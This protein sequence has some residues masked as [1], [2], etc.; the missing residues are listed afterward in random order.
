MTYNYKRY[1]K[2]TKAGE[3]FQTHETH[4]LRYKFH[5]VVL[6]FS[7]PPTT[8]PLRGKNVGWRISPTMGRFYCRAIRSLAITVFGYRCRGG[9]WTNARLYTNV[10]DTRGTR[11]QPRHPFATV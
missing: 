4:I 5:L 6:R 7:S 2:K 10:A 8:S 1:I 9:G 3:D 11:V